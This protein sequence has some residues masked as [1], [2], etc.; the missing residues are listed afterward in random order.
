MREWVKKGYP[1]EDFERG[2]AIQVGRG[3]LI[4]NTDI[5]NKAKDIGLIT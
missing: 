4:L 1:T 2:K 5:I 3:R